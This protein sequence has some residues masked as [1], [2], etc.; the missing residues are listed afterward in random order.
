MQK[1]EIN[2]SIP[3]EIKDKNSIFSY[4][5][6]FLRD[7]IS[8]EDQLQ[9]KLSPLWSIELISEYNLVQEINNKYW[10]QWGMWD[11]QKS[12]R[13]YKRKTWETIEPIKNYSKVSKS[14]VYL[15]SDLKGFKIF[16]DNNL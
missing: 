4:C 12:L 15:E 11:L 14:K 16:L 6:S 5:I 1:N 9:W 3:T 13:D 7:L 10:L 8:S 2:I